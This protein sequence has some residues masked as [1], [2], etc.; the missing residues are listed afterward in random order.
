MS[1]SSSTT[2]ASGYGQLEKGGLGHR[3]AVRPQARG[4]RTSPARER[5]SAG[6]ALVLAAFE[7]DRGQRSA[8]GAAR[9]KRESTPA[10]SS[11]RDELVQH[12][13]QARE[14]LQLGRAREVALLAEAVD[15][16]GLEAESLGRRDVVKEARRHVDVVLTVGVEPFEEALPVPG[17]GL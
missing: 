6:M 1:V 11:C 7:R 10:R 15:P 4:T 17:A 3:L 9:P 14:I 12:L 13:G 2:P 8:V 5:A 16:D